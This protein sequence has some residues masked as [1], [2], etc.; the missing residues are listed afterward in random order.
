MEEN[1]MVA[2]DV[3]HPTKA[4]PEL[5]PADW[6]KRGVYKNRRTN[7]LRS[8]THL[9][10][11]DIF[12]FLVEKGG[13]PQKIRE[14]QKRR[15]APVEAVDEV[16]ALYEDHRKSKA[17]FIRS[18]METWLLIRITAQYSAT[19][20]KQKINEVQK[21]IGPKM[22]AAK[23]DPKIKEEADALRE[24]KT[25]LE[26]EYKSLVESAGEKE[27]LLRTKIKTIGNIVLDSVHVSNN[28]VYFP[29]EHREH[30]SN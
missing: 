26:K 10:M 6:L 28:E 21:E 30:L 25:N 14:S 5:V 1:L 7:T 11:L 8:L 18:E 2:R 29:T 3:N 22:K 13:D 23:T 27:A 16:I 20:T 4:E 17:P 15:Y 9:K 19:Q 24:Q 12:D